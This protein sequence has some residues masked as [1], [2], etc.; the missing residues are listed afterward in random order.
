MQ[1]TD[2]TRFVYVL[3][4]PKFVNHLLGHNAVLIEQPG[5]T[6]RLFS[7]HSKD[8]HSPFIEGSVAQ[9]V[10]PQD[11]ASFD[12]F[13]RACLET[14]PEP[15]DGNAVG[16]LLNNG[17]KSWYEDFRRAIRLTV[18][19]AQ[20]S[21][22]EVWGRAQVERPPCFD[23]VTFNCQHF[24]DDM[25]AQGGVS[26]GERHDD[27]RVHSFE[28]GLVPNDVFDKANEGGTAGVSGFAKFAFGT[29]GAQGM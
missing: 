27:G 16:T 14:H 23:L 29:A 25:L 18:T 6:V 1:K 2:G 24:V 12:V 11:A 15:L 3:N 21:A 17:Y 28:R 26:L 8:N 4:N 20:A 7:F 13:E 22:M 5:G 19:D 9:I 10:R